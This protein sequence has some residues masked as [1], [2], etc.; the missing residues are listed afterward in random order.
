[1]SVQLRS[2]IDFS[3]GF[4]KSERA[5]KSARIQLGDFLLVEAENPDQPYVAQLLNLYEDDAQ[6]KHAVVQWFSRFTEIPE[7]KRTLLKRKVSPQEVFY[8]QTPGCN[9]DIA[10]E[11]IIKTVTVVPLHLWEE[12]PVT[13]KKT[14]TFYVKQSWD[15]KCFKDLSP[16][17]LSKLK[18]SNKEGLGISKAFIPLDTGTPVKKEA[19]PIDESPTSLENTKLG[20]E[21]KHSA[22][23]ASLAKERHSQRLANGIKSPRARK[24]LQLNS[25]Y[26]AILG[27]F[28]G[29][30]RSES[31]LQGSEVLELLDA[32]QDTVAPLKSP[33]GKRKMSFTGILSSPSKIPCPS[34]K[35]GSTFYTAEK[36]QRFMD[37]VQLSPYSKVRDTSEKS[38][39]PDMKENTEMT[40]T[41][42]EN[43][44]EGTGRPVSTLPLRK[45]ALE[46]RARISEQLS[47][48]NSVKI[49]Q[50]D[51]SQSSS[52][53]SYSSDE[54]E[55]DDIQYIPKKKQKLKRPFS[56]PK[57]S[58]NSLFHTPAKTPK[59]N[60]FPDRPR[61]SPNATPETSRRSHAVQNAASLLA[62]ARLRLHVSAVPESLPCR[63]EEFQSIYTFVE[64]KLVDGTGGC[65]YI[66]GMPGTGKTATVQEAIHCLQQAVEDDCIPS[67]QFVEINGMKLTDP[68]EFYVQLVESLTGQRVTAAHAAALL[69]KLFST[70]GA[71]RRATVL[72]AD[73][74][75][76]LWT[77]KQDVL[78]NL[79]DWPSWKHSK[80]IVLAIANTMDLPE[81]IMLNR[82][83][84]RVGFT[85]M[86]FEPYTYRELQQIILSRLNN[87]NVFEEDAVQLVAALSGDARRCLHICRRAAEICEFAGQSSTSEKVRMVHVTKAIDEMFSSPYINLIRNASLH[88]QIFL[89]ATLAEFCRT[90]LEEATLQ[91]IYHQHVALCRVE[92]IQCPTVSD[93]MSVCSRLS[94]CRLLLTDPST[95]YLYMRVRLNISQ[96]DLIY[97]LQSQNIS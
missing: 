25:M 75:D 93:I 22:S 72:V 80:L 8:D 35:S 36:W 4:I 15:G 18:V 47:I 87:I 7:N 77:Q 2:K 73:E 57:S 6:Q 16:D 60:S 78:Y 33:P 45:C 27:P 46:T 20:I 1:M 96:D 79:F 62:E 11:T 67:F 30:P 48:L 38:K 91:Q 56:T 43:K 95:K 92:G 64:S 82:V 13:L 81:R 10:L 65:M 24:R 59:K 94:A 21:S 53:T 66:A 50:E 74:L 34:D 3:W 42:I 84:S 61:T 29:P 12:L 19:E 23:K 68:H 26:M 40:A 85:R 63:E 44:T 76:L 49:K 97:A 86:P 39:D 32:D 55:D 54:E 31:Q 58:G 17:I 90:G 83:A 14:D 37:T 70:P 51:D 71:N 41:L 52:D 88:E 28:G 69:A 5:R 9:V 89:K